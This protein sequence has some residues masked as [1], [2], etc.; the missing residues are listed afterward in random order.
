MNIRILSVFTSVCLISSTSF[1]AEAS[2]M[3]KWKLNPNKVKFSGL[4]EKI[5]NL[6]GDKWRFAFGD[7]VETIT[8]DGK[9]HP[10]KYGGTWSVTKTGPNTWKSVRKHDGKVTSTSVWT[11]SNDGK[12][13]TSVSDGTRPDGSKYH[14]VF[15]AK[16][17]AGTSG[18]AGTW[19]STK[20]QLSSPAA[21]EISAWGT[22]G[23]SIAVPADKERTDLKFDGKDYP[24]KGPR[25]AKGTTMSGK[26]VNANTVE[27]TGKLKGKVQYTEQLKL[28]K[29]GKTLTATLHFPGQTKPEVDVY[30]RE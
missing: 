26:R 17:V 20:L 8:F 28:S 16:R 5:E 24:D 6:G 4:Q 12:K 15:E 21:M 18:L 29:N 3:G 11:L 22:D 27:I 2:F 13:F 25:V 1:A 7:D 30:E 9:D 19:E 14:N 10:A 23:W